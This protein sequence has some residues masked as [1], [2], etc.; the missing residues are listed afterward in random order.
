MGGGMAAPDWRSQVFAPTSATQAPVPAPQAPVPAPQAPAPRAPVPAPIA[1]N[2][3]PIE[4]AEE[5]MRILRAQGNPR[6]QN[7][8]VNPGAGPQRFDLGS[9]GAHRYLSPH[10][11]DYPEAGFKN[12]QDAL[13]FINRGFTRPQK[14]VFD[15]PEELAR[16][17]QLMMARSRANR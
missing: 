17:R 3:G 5:K 8:T 9:S 6:F 12:K 11:A 2:R 15:D 7:P 13:G 1:P 10:A 4:G 14:P 16:A